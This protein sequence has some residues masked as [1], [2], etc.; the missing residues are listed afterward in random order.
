METYFLTPDLGWSKEEWVSETQEAG[1]P[2]SILVSKALPSGLDLALLGSQEGAPGR[3]G[4]GQSCQGQQ[5]KAVKEGPLLTLLRGCVLSRGLGPLSQQSQALKGEL[6]LGPGARSFCWFPLCQ[7]MPWN[8]GPGPLP[9]RTWFYFL[10]CTGKV[11]P[12]TPPDPL[13]VGH[14]QRAGRKQIRGKDLW[15]IP[16]QLPRLPRPVNTGINWCSWAPPPPPPP[17]TV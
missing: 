7:K 13:P 12:V 4:R 5:A 11:G 10:I 17:P 9:W 16:Q 15:E 1:S 8:P 14:L 2:A 3:G 6:S